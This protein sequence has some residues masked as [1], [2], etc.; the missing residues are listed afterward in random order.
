M[1]RMDFMPAIH[2]DLSG[3]MSLLYDGSRDLGAD[4][5]K[6]KHPTIGEL[7]SVG[8]PLKLYQIILLEAVPW[9]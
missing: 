4:V 9:M 8:L 1:E 3:F 2:G 5:S 7:P 6:V